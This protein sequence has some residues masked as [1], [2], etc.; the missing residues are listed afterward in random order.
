MQHTQT[1]PL[2]GAG[3]GSISLVLAAT[4]SEPQREQWIQLLPSGDFHARDGR[5]PWV[6]HNNEAVIAS[7]LDY[8]GEK[9]I[10]IDYEHQI[11]MA[12]KNGQP[13]PA[14]GWIKQ[15]QSRADGIWGLVEWTEKARAYLTSKEYRYLSPVFTHA[16]SGEVTRILRAA[17]TNNPALELTALAT[18]QG[19]DLKAQDPLAE[20]RGL[21]GLAA[22]ADMTGIVQAVRDLM[23]E[24]CNSKPDP[25]KFVP[26][27]T[28]QEVLAHASVVRRQTDETSA[29]LAVDQAINQRHILPMHRDFALELCRS[30]RNSFEQ[31]TSAVSPFLLGFRQTQT[32]GLSPEQRGV[33]KAVAY[34]DNS[35][36]AVC[37]ALGHSAEEFTQLGASHVA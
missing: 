20:L 21:L 34:L 14:A 15:L 29:V 28:L 25:A 10:P 35:E 31:F 13:A 11:D 17:L 9:P 32:G 7:S 12:A 3:I 22:D 24:T 1:H 36:Q 5:G 2:T 19:T 30:D 23:A 37:N 16:P 8:A 27:E 33:R 26:I 6:I 18:T 4:A